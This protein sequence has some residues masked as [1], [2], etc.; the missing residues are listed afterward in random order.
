[1]LSFAEFSNLMELDRDI[2]TCASLFEET[3]FEPEDVVEQVLEAE[4]REGW[5][6]WLSGAGRAAGRLGRAAG[7]VGGSFWSGGLKSGLAK[8]SDTVSGPAV[9]FDKA[10]SVLS[11]LADFLNSNDMTRNLPSA[12]KSG[13]TVGQY[14]KAVTKAL[15]KEKDNIPQMQ[16]AQVA[17]TMAPRDGGESLA[18]SQ[19]PSASPIVGADGK[20]MMRKV[21]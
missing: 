13:Y 4:L 14:I 18:A 20:P 9:K 12:G 7:E 2:R 15:M 21:V 16:K 5:R 6:D 1:M 8:A 3:A 11:G 10:V 17:Q 19:A